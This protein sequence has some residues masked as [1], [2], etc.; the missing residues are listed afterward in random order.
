MTKQ[1]IIRESIISVGWSNELFFF[2][3]NLKKLLV[4][5]VSI[6]STRLSPAN[7]HLISLT[8][9][10]TA[11]TN[12]DYWSEINFKK[13]NSSLI[14]FIKFQKVQLL[15][16][17]IMIYY[18]FS[19]FRLLATQIVVGCGSWNLRAAPSFQLQKYS[20]LRLWGTKQKIHLKIIDANITNTIK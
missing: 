10:P 11:L 7:S 6:I 8:R 16:S 15:S 14:R 4:S 5:I 2:T 12:S 3:Q 17:C 1:N 18:D 20:K 13:K 9:Y 19:F